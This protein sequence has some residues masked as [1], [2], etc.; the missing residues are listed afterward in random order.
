MWE[1]WEVVLVTL[2]PLR[3]VL[4]LFFWVL[5]QHYWHGALA[6][7][8]DL[9]TERRNYIHRWGHGGGVQPQINTSV[10]A[11]CNC[12]AY[13]SS[14]GDSIVHANQIRYFAWQLYWAVHSVPFSMDNYAQVSL[15]SFSVKKVFWTGFP[16]SGI[17]PRFAA[18]IWLRLS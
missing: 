12:N 9:C 15:V 7:C 13:V 14:T 11:A 10:N 2:L 3:A 16:L 5:E 17:I 8:G 6:G 4:G 1:D 18:I